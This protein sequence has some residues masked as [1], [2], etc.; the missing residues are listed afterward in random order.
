M[1]STRHARSNA[2]EKR[3]KRGYL[4]LHHYVE[5]M[6]I[7]NYIQSGQLNL[8]Q[9]HRLLHPHN[10]TKVVLRAYHGHKLYGTSPWQ[11]VQRLL[12]WRNM[13]G[14]DDAWVDSN[15][16]LPITILNH[17]DDYNTAAVAA[18]AFASRL[19][20][21]DTEATLGSLPTPPPGRPS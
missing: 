16:V 21:E 14:S 17:P 8:S 10:F 4:D 3:A 13:G 6:Y 2:A 12:D 1:A 19:A 7:R 20:I 5:W 11:D 9:R 18:D 15:V